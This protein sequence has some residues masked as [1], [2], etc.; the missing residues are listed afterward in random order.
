[1]LIQ[2]AEIGPNFRNTSRGIASDPII[3]LTTRVDTRI[4]PVPVDT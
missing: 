2:G 1:M 4:E 3:R